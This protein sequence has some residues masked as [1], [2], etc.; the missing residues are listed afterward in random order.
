MKAILALMFHQFNSISNLPIRFSPLYTHPDDWP[1][2]LP[3][4]HESYSYTGQG[5]DLY[6]DIVEH[7]REMI[8]AIFHSPF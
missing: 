6:E 4:H 7:R 5:W 3:E 1:W 8:E 2:W